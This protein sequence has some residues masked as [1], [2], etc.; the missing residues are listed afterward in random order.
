MCLGTFV[1]EHLFIVYNVM[2]V[3]NGVNCIHVLKKTCVHF[4]YNT[5]CVQCQDCT[6]S[7]QFT[8]C[9]QSKL[10]VDK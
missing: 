2:I 10:F 1:R 8:N 5:Y 3:Y 4:K 6:Q 7:K 9:T